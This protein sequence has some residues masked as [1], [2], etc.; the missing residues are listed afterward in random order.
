LPNIFKQFSQ[1]EP[2]HDMNKGGLGL[3]LSIVKILVAKHKGTV[4]AASEGVGQGSTFIVRLPLRTGEA[5]VTPPPLDADMKDS[6][7]LKGVRILVIEDDNDSREVLQLFLEQMGASVESVPSAKDAWA[8]FQRNYGHLPNVIV[9]DLAMPEED[10]YSLISRIRQLPPE[11]GGRI[12]ALALSAFATSE[13]KARAL[14]CGFD[15]YSSKPFEPELITHDI[16][17]LLKR[18]ERDVESLPA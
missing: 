17:S 13:S 4:T 10:G 7:A 18:R 1:V 3:G 16:L 11:Q 6:L 15:Q 5:A 8:V 2:A 14:E 9:S 12:P